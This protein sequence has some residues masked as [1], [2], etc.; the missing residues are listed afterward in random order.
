MACVQ[1]MSRARQF[2]QNLHQPFQ[3]HI[4]L[5]KTGKDNNNK[6]AVIN[7]AHTNNGNLCI[8]IFDCYVAV[9]FGHCPCDVQVEVGL[10]IAQQAIAY[11][12]LVALHPLVQEAEC[13]F[14]L[15]PA[16]QNQEERVVAH[17]RLVRIEKLDNLLVRKA[18]AC[19]LCGPMTAF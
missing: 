2:A 9:I 3:L 15:D 18:A 16:P 5:A 11:I 4:P 12:L 7:T 14:R 1:D 8:S 19:I 6:N 10:A 13:L 17:L